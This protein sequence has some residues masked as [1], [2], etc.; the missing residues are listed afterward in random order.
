MCSSVL[1][2]TDLEHYLWCPFIVSMESSEWAGQADSQLLSVCGNIHQRAGILLLIE[3]CVPL[4]FGACHTKR[5]TVN[6][7]DVSR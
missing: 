5:I 7:D 1:V 2:C 4:A 6:T 3:P